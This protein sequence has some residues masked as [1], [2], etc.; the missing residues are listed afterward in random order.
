M[1]GGLP[2]DFT[3]RELH[4][5]RWTLRRRP[6]ALAR[7]TSALHALTTPVSKGASQAD[8]GFTSELRTSFPH[9]T[10]CLFRTGRTCPI[11]FGPPAR[12]RI[13]QHV[14]RQPW[15]GS[16]V[17]R[18]H[19]LFSVPSLASDDR[20]VAVRVMTQS[21]RVAVRVAQEQS[22]LWRQQCRERGSDGSTGRARVPCS[23]AQSRLRCT[24]WCDQ[25]L[26]VRHVAPRA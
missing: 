16:S 25:W 7:L 13:R 5:G 14:S 12:C 17:T 10:P 1:S 23:S 21:A 26:I 15:R 8:L 6:Q 4:V 3:H 18:R 19:G 20:V 22:R 24:G 11:T 9:L 2:V